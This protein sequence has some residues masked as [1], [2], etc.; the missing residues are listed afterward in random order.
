MTKSMCP[1]SWQIPAGDNSPEGQLSV[2][3]E[4]GQVPLPSLL[5]LPS[6]TYTGRVLLS[7]TGGCFSRATQ[8]E[9]RIW[10]QVCSPRFQPG[11]PGEEAVALGQQLED[12][13]RST[14]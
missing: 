8:P 9:S 4:L 10:A 5:S 6:P 1:S 13:L 11:R 3:V 2:S 7:R 14:R 12:T